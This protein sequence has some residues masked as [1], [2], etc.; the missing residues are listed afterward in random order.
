MLKIGIRHTNGAGMIET[1]VAP[2]RLCKWTTKL[3]KVQTFEIMKEAES[4]AKYI[5][6]NAFSVEVFKFK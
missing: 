5:T 1:V 2:P 6:D 3:N 4:A